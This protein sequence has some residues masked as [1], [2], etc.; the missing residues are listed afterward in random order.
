MSQSPLDWHLSGFYPPFL[1]LNI[2]LLQISILPAG[3][4]L[5][6]EWTEISVGPGPTPSDPM[7]STPIQLRFDTPPPGDIPPGALPPT[8]A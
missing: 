5:D 8:E 6:G 4:P 3:P 1:Y 7:L 2:G